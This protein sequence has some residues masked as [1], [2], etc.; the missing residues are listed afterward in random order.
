MKGR[1]MACRSFGKSALLTRRSLVKAGGMG[2]MGMTMPGLMRAA[3]Q[4][5]GLKARAKSVI[6]LFQWGGPSHLDMFD[7]K[8]DAPREYRGPYRPMRSSSDE[9][10]VCEH[11]PETA[12]IMDR[13]SLV[14]S[15]HH[16]MNNHNSAGYYALTGKAPA[17]DDQRLRDSLDLFPGYGS[18]VSKLSP[19]GDP[20]IPRYV[21]YPYKVADGSKTP[22]QHASFLGKDYDPLFVP[23]NP[24]EPDFGLPE[25]VLPQGLSLDRLQH[26][27]GLQQI[28]DRQKRLI[29]HSAEAL[30]M[31]RYYDRA[32]GM[33][34]SDQ[35][36]HAFDL[37][38][39]PAVVRDAYGRSDY[40]QGCL[41]GRR[42][43]EHG[44]KFVTCYFSGSIGGRR[45]TDGG[46]DTHGFDNTRMFPI[47]EKRHLPMTE[48]TLPTLILDLEQRGMLDETLVV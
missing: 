3:E 37:S 42:L 24:N 44:V 6:F 30:G 21:S 15:V 26:R 9:I 34:Q 48:Q 18:V 20:R 13:V 35:L 38:R 40:G 17:S 32:L 41:L 23:R 11:L 7:M 29:D 33:L 46:W 2:L 25:L 1:G 31:D 16:T 10:E 12:K 4:S 39:E 47:I 22:G 43:V 14:R 5:R 28:I 36:R 19:G 8:P 27:R 45:T